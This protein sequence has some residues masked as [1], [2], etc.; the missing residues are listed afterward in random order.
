MAGEVTCEVCK[1]RVPGFDSVHYGGPG[2]SHQLC[3]K[4]FNEAISDRNGLDFEHPEL[5]PITIADCEGTPH[6]FH[7]RSHLVPTG[8]SIEAFELEDGN[9]AGYQFMVLGDP[10]ADPRDLFQELVARIRR[11][12]SRKYLEPSDLGLL[13]A[14]N[15]DRHLVQGRIDCDPESDERVPLL[16]IDGKE[17]TWAQFGRMLMSFEGFQ[18]QLEIFDSTEELP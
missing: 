15:H 13:I 12:L 3:S 10:E 9:M 6:T 4:C 5:E 14:K 1:K 16:V 18:L 8:L 17:I 7:F 2:A 11:G